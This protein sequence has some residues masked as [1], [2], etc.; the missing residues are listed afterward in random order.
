MTNL[1]IKLEN[2]PPY[3]AFIPAM[4][5]ETIRPTFEELLGKK[6]EAI[7]TDPSVSDEE[8]SLIEQLLIHFKPQTPKDSGKA[9]EIVNQLIAGANSDHPYLNFYH[10][11]KNIFDQHEPSDGVIKRSDPDCKDPSCVIPA[12]IC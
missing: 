1:K 6:V 9:F 3:F 5:T 4:Q 11:L 12:F 10:F 2:I 7:L 8:K